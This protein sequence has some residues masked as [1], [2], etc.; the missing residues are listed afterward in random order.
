MF[1]D[2]LKLAVNLAE[3]VGDACAVV[4]ILGLVGTQ[5]LEKFGMVGSILLGVGL[6]VFLR[7]EVTG[8]GE[9]LNVLLPVLILRGSKLFFG[10]EL[11]N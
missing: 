3:L 1:D 11:F 2:Q 6:K 10:Y 8:A 7:N 9:K 5:R 4:C